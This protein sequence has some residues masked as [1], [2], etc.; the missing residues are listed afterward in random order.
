MQLSLFG[1]EASSLKWFLPS[2][3]VLRGAGRLL[4][5]FLVPAARNCF[6]C[7]SRPSGRPPIPCNA[8]KKRFSINR[9]NLV[10]C[11]DFC[12]V[13]RYPVPIVEPWP[14]PDALP[15][16]GVWISCDRGQSSGYGCR[17]HRQ[18]SI[19]CAGWAAAMNGVPSCARATVSPLLLSRIRPELGTV[20]RPLNNIDWGEKSCWDDFGF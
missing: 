12:K 13:R 18:I 17:N 2:V 14:A 7:A 9:L 4:K 15:V 8:T 11:I 19:F 20:S 3:D 6:T 1:Q 16:W 10:A 5:T